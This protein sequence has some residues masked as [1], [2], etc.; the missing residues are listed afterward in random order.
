MLVVGLSPLLLWV[1]QANSGWEGW[2]TIWRFF[3]YWC[4]PIYVFHFLMSWEIESGSTIVAYHLGYSAVGIYH[5][6]K[7]LENLKTTPPD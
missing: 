4:R 5:L 2:E 3:A 6:R 7:H 1:T